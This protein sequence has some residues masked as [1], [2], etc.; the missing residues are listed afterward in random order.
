[1]EDMETRLS[2]LEA[3]GWRLEGWEAGGWRLAAPD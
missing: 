1:M 2:G 3:G